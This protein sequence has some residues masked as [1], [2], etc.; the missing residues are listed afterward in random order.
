MEFVISIT[1]ISI[2][3]YL[4][5]LSSYERLKD[6][7]YFTFSFSSVTFYSMVLLKE[8]AV[9]NLYSNVFFKVRP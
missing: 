8:I 4:A 5:Q 6:F 1:E 7:T 9:C 2:F 3:F